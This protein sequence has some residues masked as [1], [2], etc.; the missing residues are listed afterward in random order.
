MEPEILFLR[1]P[2]S[3]PALTS[4]VDSHCKLGLLLA[5]KVYKVEARPV[6]GLT[7]EP[8]G[9]AVLNAKL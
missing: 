2:K 7:D 6:S 3:R 4:V 8:V 1:K 9:D 5:L